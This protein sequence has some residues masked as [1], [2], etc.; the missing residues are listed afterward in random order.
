[1]PKLEAKWFE[2][3]E[4]LKYKIGIE[5]DKSLIK[6]Y[7][8]IDDSIAAKNNNMC[9]VMYCE[10]EDPSDP[11]ADPDMA[12]VSL[13]CGHQYRACAWADFLK[14][15]VKDEGTASLFAKCPQLRCNVVVPHTIFLQYLKDEP[16][17]D[18][19]NYRKKYITWHTMQFTD[20]NKSMKVCSNVKGGC[21]RII[22]KNEFTT[23]NNVTCGCGASYCFS[24]ERENHEPATCVHVSKWLEKEGEGDNETLEWI[25]KNTKLCPTCKTSVEKNAGCSSMVC[26]KCKTSFCWMCLRIFQDAHSCE[27][28]RTGQVISKEEGNK[29][30]AMQEE[31]N[32][33]SFH[34]YNYE[35]WHNH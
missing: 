13:C 27:C 31:Q 11:D 10:F 35:R 32:E 14:T 26:G 22:E 17:D 16:A 4:E 33:L 5:Y 24:C 34:H 6:K 3:Q 9:M 19:V 23:A 21:E 29:T 1:M 12:P 28:Y 15:K 2:N 20:N 7:P 25:K 18:G 30:E 8:E